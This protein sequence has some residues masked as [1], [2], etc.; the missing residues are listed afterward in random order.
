MRR[1]TS[2]VGIPA[3]LALARQPKAE[4]GEEVKQIPAKQLVFSY[5]GAY[6]DAL[7]GFTTR[8]REYRE[9]FDQ[10][11]LSWPNMEAILHRACF[12]VSPGFQS[13]VE[14]EPLLESAFRNAT[15]A[16]LKV[17]GDEAFEPFILA[18]LNT[19]AEQ[20]A[21]YD[22]F[23]LTEDG[24]QAR[25]HMHD[26]PLCQWATGFHEVLFEVRGSILGQ[27]R[28][29]RAT[30]LLLAA[31]I[32]NAHEMGLLL[33]TDPQDA[34]MSTLPHDPLR[35]LVLPQSHSKGSFVRR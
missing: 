28:K 26:A 22:L 19:L 8:Y 4:G 1:L 10:I 2:A 13:P 29:E 34:T 15:R 32:L 6:Q 35:S 27:A 24:S 5:E 9:D 7:A 16:G 21:E 11:C 18:F 31:R 3:L 23:G 17:I 30:A 20:F 25:W 12:L 33:P 14:T